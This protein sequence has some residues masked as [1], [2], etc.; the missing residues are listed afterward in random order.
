VQAAPGRPLVRR[1]IQSG[2]R[3]LLAGP[4]SARVDEPPEAS[5][6]VRAFADSREAVDVAPM[7]Q[8]APDG[9]I[10]TGTSREPALAPEAHGL[11]VARAVAREA[12]R[13]LPALADA[14]VIGTWSGVRPVT[15]DERPIVGRLA[16]GLIVASGHGSEGVILGGG[17]AEL[18]RA[19]VTGDE[20]P[21]DAAPFDPHRF[22][23]QG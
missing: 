20:P 14:P 7:I 1:W 23:E 5:L 17:T 6:S 18:V 4:E 12:S 8:P 16:D 13:L 19:I 21:F 3:R 10:V 22:E 15:P 11:E 9:S 2:A